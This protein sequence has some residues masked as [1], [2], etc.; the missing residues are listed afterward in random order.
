MNISKW[1]EVRL[2]EITTYLK[3]RISGLIENILDDDF[4]RESFKL[5]GIYEEGD[6]I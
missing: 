6:I 1:D 2:N 3:N 4:N 5:T